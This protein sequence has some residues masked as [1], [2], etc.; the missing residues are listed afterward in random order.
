VKDEQQQYKSINIYIDEDFSPRTSGLLIDRIKYLKGTL[1]LAIQVLILFEE[2][3][4]RKSDPVML[5][6]D[7]K[8]SNWR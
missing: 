1:I 6:H 5:F 7:E 8:S 3:N 4:S 2:K